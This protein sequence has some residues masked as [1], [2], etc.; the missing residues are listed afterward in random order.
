MHSIKIA[1]IILLLGCFTTMDDFQKFSDAFEEPRIRKL[2][3]DGQSLKETKYMAY[4]S[5]ICNDHFS[6]EGTFLFLN[7]IKFTFSIG[8][9]FHQGLAWNQSVLFFFKRPFFFFL[10]GDLVTMQNSRI[11]LQMIQ[12]TE[13]RRKSSHFS[14]FSCDLQTQKHSV[15]IW[16][17]INLVSGKA[18]HFPYDKVGP[19]SPRTSNPLG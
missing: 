3:P 8:S 4:L 6:Y 18:E 7:L 1:L 11:S 19:I 17:G 9:H 16:R 12:K 13:R 15:I 2:H 5:T 10:R 14:P